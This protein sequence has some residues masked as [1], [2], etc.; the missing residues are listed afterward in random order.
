MIAAK[1]SE[2]NHTREPKLGRRLI[3]RRIVA[4]KFP[5]V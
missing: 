5:A 3:I 1:A 2:E 4:G